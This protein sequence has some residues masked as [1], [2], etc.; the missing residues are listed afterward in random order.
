[1]TTQELLYD[2]EVEFKGYCIYISNI[3]N[4]TLEYIK[5]H[6]DCEI[7]KKDYS[8]MNIYNYKIYFNYDNYEYEKLIIYLRDNGYKYI[9]SLL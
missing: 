3:S 2:V 6:Y 5:D 1:M 7:Y 9:R 8:T 4:S